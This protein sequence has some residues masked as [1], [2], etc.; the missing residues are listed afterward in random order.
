[1]DYQIKFKKRTYLGV[2]RQ[3]GFTLI[4]LIMVIAI[5]GI[6][7]AI[8]SSVYVNLKV[9][10]NLKI[11]TGSLVQALRY[12]EENAQIGKNDLKWGV[13]ILPN[14]VVIFGGDS[15]SNRDTSLD[16]ILNFP[17]GIVPS[18]NSEFV[19][20]KITGWT[21]TTGTATITNNSGV[22]NISVNEKGTITY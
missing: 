5:F 22:K 17:S 14:K 19:F 2:V 13:E 7:F 8:S 12:A 21:T 9:S 6:L 1:M 4:E 15:Y 11:T 16:Q 20:E 3:S 18:G 10:S